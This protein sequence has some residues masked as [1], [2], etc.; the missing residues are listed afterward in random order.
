[1]GSHY[2]F[3]LRSWCVCVCV[4]VCVKVAVCEVRKTTDAASCP[5][6]HKVCW[7]VFGCTGDCMTLRGRQ[8][9]FYREKHKCTLDLKRCEA[10]ARSLL[11]WSRADTDFNVRHR[12]VWNGSPAGSWSLLPDAEQRLWHHLE[13]LDT[14]NV[15]CSGPLCQNNTKKFVRGELDGAGPSGGVNTSDS[16]A[17]LRDDFGFL[18]TPVDRPDCSSDPELTSTVGCRRGNKMNFTSWM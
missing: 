12:R 13:T 7:G 10:Q 15:T 2:S 5:E 3:L 17:E 18:S 8:M 1:M 14:Q 11:L 6:L 16:G 9:D 4:C